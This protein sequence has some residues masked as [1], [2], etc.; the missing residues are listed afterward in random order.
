MKKILALGL[1]LAVVLLIGCIDNSPYTLRLDDKLDSTGPYGE[2]YIQ[3]NYTD[4]QIFY[5][6]RITTFENQEDLSATLENY[7]TLYNPAQI[8]LDTKY[9]YYSEL[10][11][12]GNTMNYFY[13]Y[14]S[15]NHLV[16]IDSTHDKECDSCE[17]K[18]HDFVRWFYSKYPN[19]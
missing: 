12:P 7:M 13:F 18:S 11:E 15:D 14:K 1:I 2:T 4:G 8:V 19:N 17:P 16:Q 10:G 5:S 9:V 3:Q 6:A